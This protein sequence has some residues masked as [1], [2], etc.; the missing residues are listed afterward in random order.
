MEGL[1]NKSTN[2]QIARSV[3]CASSVKKRVRGLLGRDGV[4]ESY[5]L[6]ILPCPAIHTF[7][8]KFP[9][10]VIFADKHLKVV[11]VFHSVPSRRVIFGGWKGHSVFELKAAQLKDFNMKKGDQL[12]VGH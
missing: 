2:K 8:M 4:P 9:I 5:A 11:S 3:E 6:W 1:I 10:D 12:Y 7:F